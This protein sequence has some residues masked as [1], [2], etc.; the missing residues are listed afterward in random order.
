MTPKNQMLYLI[1]NLDFL[2]FASG[3]RD[4][5]ALRVGREGAIPFKYDDVDPLEGI[6][7]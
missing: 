3:T 6:F 2:I 5:P 4:I 1:L 7:F